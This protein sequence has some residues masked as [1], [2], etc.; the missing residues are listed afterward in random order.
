MAY[1]MKGP[2]FFKDSIRKSKHGP[3]P[4]DPKSPLTQTTS[5]TGTGWT[6]GDAAK[7]YAF[8][9]RPTEEKPVEDLTKKTNTKKTNTK[10]TTTKKTSSGDPYAKAKKKDPNL[11]KYIAERKK[12]KPGSA[13][14]EAI[15]AKVNAAYGKTRSQKVKAAQIK[16]AEDTEVKTPDGP[17]DYGIEKYKDEDYKRMENTSYKEKRQKDKAVTLDKKIGEKATKLEKLKSETE[18][19]GKKYNKKGKKRT[20]AGRV[21]QWIKRGFVKRSKRRK[22]NK[23]DR[24]RKK[25]DTRDDAEKTTTTTSTD[26]T[27]TDATSTGTTSGKKSQT[28]AKQE[29]INKEAAKNRRANAILSAA[30]TISS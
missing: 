12:H 3:K 8:V 29:L 4:M 6:S 2:T 18:A 11:D 10:K 19:G 14:Y 30:D 25:I 24:L 26:A 16:K 1:K 15:Q 21:G 5:V 22:E 9:T 7:P 20:A 23:A 13:E 27:S 28:D 17:K